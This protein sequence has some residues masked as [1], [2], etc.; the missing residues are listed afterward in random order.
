ML[1]QSLCLKGSHSLPPTLFLTDRLEF[2]V[3]SILCA[4]APNSSTFIL[5]RAVTGI[6]AAGLFQEALCIIAL[7]VPL[8]KRSLFLGIV[9]SSF[10]LATCFGPILGGALTNDVSWRW[11]F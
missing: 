11:C 2:T 10:G 6:G 7:S 4:A 3:G 5:V 8:E 9:I 1:S